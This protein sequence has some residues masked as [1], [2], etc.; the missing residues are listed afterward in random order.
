MS[1]CSIFI[2]MYDE[3]WNPCR[4]PQCKGFLPAHFPINEQF[5]CR[6]C[7][8]VL[9]TLPSLVE[10]SDDEEDLD[11]KYGGRICL[12]PEVAIT[13]DTTL[14]PKPKRHHKKRT[15]MWAI[16]RAFSRRVW[17]DHDGQFIEIY[18][19]RIE[20]TDSRILQIVEDQPSEG[21]KK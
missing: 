19:E 3:E 2:P 6:K 12:V 10:Y 11:Y 8:S 13:I 5:L 4:C 1:Q 18:P 14:P 20:L 21:S 7:G 15:N 16:G 9:E 17:E